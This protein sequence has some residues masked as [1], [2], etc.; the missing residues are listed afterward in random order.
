MYGDNIGYVTVQSE[1]SFII[2]IMTRARRWFTIVVILRVKRA[3]LLPEFYFKQWHKVIKL[4]VP[5][6]M[7]EG[8]VF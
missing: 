3:L 8:V 5:V 7:K 1:A 2:V 4:P 6:I